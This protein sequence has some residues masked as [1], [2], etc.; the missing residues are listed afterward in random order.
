M[1]RKRN[2][3]VLETRPGDAGGASTAAYKGDRSRGGPWW[4]SEG[5]IV[6]LRAWD[7]IT[8]PEGKDP[9]LF[10]QLKGGG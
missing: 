8:R 9:A 3:P 10:A 7:N 4:E 5:S 1:L 6:R 2:N